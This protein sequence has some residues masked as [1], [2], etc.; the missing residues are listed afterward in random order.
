MKLTI[1]LKTVQTAGQLKRFL[2]NIDDDTSFM[3]WDLGDALVDKIY[4]EYIEYEHVPNDLSI[5]VETSNTIM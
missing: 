2:E 1:D 4:M 5:N 3:F